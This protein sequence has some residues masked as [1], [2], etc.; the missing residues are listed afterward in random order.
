MDN[1]TAITL[2]VTTER[3]ARAVELLKPY[4]PNVYFRLRRTLSAELDRRRLGATEHP[5]VI[6]R[7]FIVGLPF[8]VKE[9]LRIE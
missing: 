3:L 9:V 5:F 7:R 8:A 1:L 4:D 2:T 6:S